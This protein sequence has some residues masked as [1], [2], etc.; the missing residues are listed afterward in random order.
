MV[1]LQPNKKR[2]SLIETS[3]TWHETLLTAVLYL[4]DEECDGTTCIST[5]GG[6]ACEVTVR[7]TEGGSA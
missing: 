4:L 5:P 7:F 6:R 1:E 3:D 2:P